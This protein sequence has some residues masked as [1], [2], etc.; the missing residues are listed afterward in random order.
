MPTL[1]VELFEGRTKE[2]KADLARELTQA[3]VRVLGSK[4]EGVDVIFVDVKKENWASG[5]V[6]WSERS[7]N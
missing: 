5:G 7:A 1:H 6:L 2:Q 4:P 3:C